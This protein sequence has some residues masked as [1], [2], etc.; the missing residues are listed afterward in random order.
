MKPLRTEALELLDD[1]VE[2][3]H[4]QLTIFSDSLQRLMSTPKKKEDIRTAFHAIHTIKGSAGFLAI[5]ELVHISHHIESLLEDAYTTALSIET[6]ESLLDI[7]SKIED[8]ITSCTKAN[9]PIMH[10]Q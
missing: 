8:S 5:Q 3:A 9:V 6:I 2:E 1:F 4:E 10:T 7:A